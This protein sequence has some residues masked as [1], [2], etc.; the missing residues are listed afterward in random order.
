VQPSKPRTGLP[1]R[2]PP[3]TASPDEEKTRDLLL[4]L[5][6]AQFEGAAA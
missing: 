1:E 5:L 2:T 4:V 3:M 6:N